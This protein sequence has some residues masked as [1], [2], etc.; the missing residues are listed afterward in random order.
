[1]A[2]SVTGQKGDLASGEGAQDVRVRGR[3]EGSFKMNF[4]NAGQALH[5]IEPAAAD[6]ADLCL[7]Q[8]N[9]PQM[10]EWAKKRLYRRRTPAQYPAQRAK[11]LHCHGGNG[12]SEGSVEFGG[13][14]GSKRFQ[15]DDGGALDVEADQ[16]FL[17]GPLVR[18]W[19]GPDGR[20]TRGEG[21]FVHRG[22][23]I[24]GIVRGKVKNQGKRQRSILGSIF[25][26]ER[27]VIAP[28]P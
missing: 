9:L 12:G 23:L 8:C 19:R 28:S 3:A 20:V 2:A 21:G 26:G 7:C 17:G 5:G 1:M 16:A 18:S 15:R 22:E 10:K 11:S 24:G 6:D 13:V 4:V 27:H 25:L 14:T